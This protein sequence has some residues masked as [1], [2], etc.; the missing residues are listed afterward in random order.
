MLDYQSV[1]IQQWLKHSA[2][3]SR[4]LRR[5]KSV[6]R[7]LGR[8][9]FPDGRAEP[10]PPEIGRRDVV[11]FP[12]RQNDRGTRHVGDA[13]RCAGQLARNMFRKSMP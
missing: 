6:G 3:Y 13:L 9:R 1:A 12:M 10:D 7:R 4:V 2:F 11:E 5:T 8:H